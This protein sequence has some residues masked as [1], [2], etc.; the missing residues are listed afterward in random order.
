MG[1]STRTAAEE[2]WESCSGCNVNACICTHKPAKD[3][4]QV[5]LAIM[6]WEEKRNAMI[7]EFGKDAKDPGLEESVGS[8]W[9]LAERREGADEARRDRVKIAE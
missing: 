1:D 2:H 5:K 9:N 3:V 7:S 4:S 6:Q 8:F